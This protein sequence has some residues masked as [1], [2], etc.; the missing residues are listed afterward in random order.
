MTSHQTHN[1]SD[2]AVKK[3]S[4]GTNMN[5]DLIDII[6]ND[7]KPIKELINVMKDED[8]SFEEKKTPL[9]ISRRL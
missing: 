8:A 1:R 6:L 4:L 7:H 9:K 3:S 5:L 2:R